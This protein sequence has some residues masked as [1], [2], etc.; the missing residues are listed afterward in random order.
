MGPLAVCFAPVADPVDRH[1]A[2]PEVDVVEDAIVPD[3][4]AIAASRPRQLAD[5]IRERAVRKCLDG[6][7]QTNDDPRVKASEVPVDGGDDGDVK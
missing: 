5:A 1:V 7:Q 3:A 2:V 4:E 6:R